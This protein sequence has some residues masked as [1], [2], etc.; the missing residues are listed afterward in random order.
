MPDIF[1]AP[2]GESA[3]RCV[4]KALILPILLLCGHASAQ[5]RPSSGTRVTCYPSYD[6]EYFYFAATVSQAAVQATA[7]TPFSDPLSGDSVAVFL[8]RETPP[9]GA[10]RSARS[11]EMAVSAAG[12]SQLYRGAEA[13]P[14]H[15][16]GD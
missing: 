13:T 14:L 12:G 11:V 16:F 6:A 2:K 15:G 5:N 10:K 7:K 9:T 4:A 1:T 8:Q 3:M